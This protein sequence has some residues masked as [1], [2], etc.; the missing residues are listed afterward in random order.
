[1][2]H[3]YGLP[4]HGNT[5][6]TTHSGG[7]SNVINDVLTFSADT[8]GAINTFSSTNGGNNYTA[9]PFALIQN[10]LVDKFNQRNVVLKYDTFVSG[11][12]SNFLADDVL[13]QTQPQSQLVLTHN[14]ANDA[15]FTVGEGVVQVVNS[16]VNNYAQVRSVP[17]TSTLVLGSIVR[18]TNGSNFYSVGHDATFTANILTGFLS[19]HTV[20]TV[21]VQSLSLIHI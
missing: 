18:K 1:M 9:P 6:N 12:R 3:G 8:L 4:K 5:I 16:T 17:N 19:D 10:R 14:G 7:Y 13:V 21:T 15:A 20:N 2:K 11:T